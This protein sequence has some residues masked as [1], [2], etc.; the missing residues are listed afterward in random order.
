MKTPYSASEATLPTDWR[1]HRCDRLLG[2]REA[3]RVHIRFS[4]GA[5]YLASLPVTATCRGCGALNDLD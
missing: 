1:C 4:R 5:E 2:R 3:G